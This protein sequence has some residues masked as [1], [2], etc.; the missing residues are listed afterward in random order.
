MNDAAASPT[1]SYEDPRLARARAALADARLQMPGLLADRSDADDHPSTAS[2]RPTENTD[3]ETDTAVESSDA[4]QRLDDIEDRIVQLEEDRRRLGSEVSAVHRMVE[5]L[6]ETLATFNARRSPVTNPAV[7]ALGDGRLNAV[8]SPRAS[9]NIPSTEGG[10]PLP[11]AAT[12]EVRLLSVDDPA[13]LASLQVSLARQPELD[14]VRFVRFAEGEASFRCSLR[15][16][17]SEVELLDLL[18]R[19]IPS[20]KPLAGPAPGHLLLRMRPA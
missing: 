10:P 1:E 17:R 6:R 11:A 19:V 9:G 5:E 20:A 8:A 14:G 2:L 7:G 16:P 4:H 12:V 15:R 3:P 13:I 18:Q